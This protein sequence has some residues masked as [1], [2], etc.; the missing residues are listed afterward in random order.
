MIYCKQS[1][2]LICSLKNQCKSIKEIHQIHSQIITRGLLSLHPSS[3]SYLHATILH[4]FNSVISSPPQPPHRHH[5][6]SIHY[7]LSIFNLISNPSIFCWNT[8]IRS[9]TL[10]SLPENAVFFFIRMRRRCVRPDAHTFPFVLKA[11]AQLR[12][13]SLAKTIQSQSLK[14]GFTTDVFVCN[15]LIHVYCHCGLIDDAYKVLD[16]SA[17]RDVVSYNVILDGLVKAGE[18]ER[19]RQVFEEM[20]T[21]DSATWGTMLSGYTQ[22]KHYNECLDLYD[23]M[24]VLGIHPDNTSLVSV[25]SSC[26]RL[27]KLEKGKEVH[28]HIKRSKIQIDSFLCTA[29]V[30]FYSKCGCIEIAMEIFEATSDKNL[31]TW[32]AMLV[33]LA[34]NSHGKMLLN[35]FSKMVKNRVKPDGVT[36]LGVLLGCSHAGL[37]DEA[38]TLFA[39]MEV[40]YGVPKELK[41]YGS[42]ADLLGRGGLIKEAM[43]M[44]ESMPMSG[45]VFVW[46]SLLGGCKLHGN[47][48][49][50]EKAAECIMEISPEDGG[51]YSTMADI[52]ANAKRW[53][54][55]TKIR[56]LRDSR[57]VKKNAGCSLIELDGVSHEFVSGA[58]CTRPMGMEKRKLKI[59]CWLLMILCLAQIPSRLALENIRIAHSKNLRSIVQESQGLGIM[60]L[61]GN[62]ELQ[63]QDAV[64]LAKGQKGG[65]GSG[66]G[67]ID[68]VPHKSESWN[69][70]AHQLGIFVVV[71]TFCILQFLVS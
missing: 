52:Y 38:R 26:S 30:D 48:E 9:H 34:I 40:V 66:G 59:L 63:E 44:I 41:H 12:E 53:D 4:T 14:F 36:F 13:L 24:L 28:D 2:D 29:L 68:R 5:P 51:V 46:G 54:D 27:G 11:C 64:M 37:I 18:T 17:H 25:L 43:E 47:V 35:F 32:N 69:E 3:A 8:I 7:P 60:T 31:F 71:I 45:D 22:T 65:R 50:A 57:R 56:R 67:T 61:N 6:I 16:E 39:E 21:R 23:Q 19:A 42:M 20:P 49:V 70:A 62:R 33:G 55:L 58:E 15:N 1:A 10:L